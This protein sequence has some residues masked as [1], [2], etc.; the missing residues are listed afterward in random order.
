MAQ[1]A[2]AM[3]VNPIEADGADAHAYGYGLDRNPYAWNM[4]RGPE[5]ERNRIK[6]E[7]W[8]RG[9]A[10]AANATRARLF[11]QCQH[12]DRIGTFL[13]THGRAL[14]SAVFADSV[15]LYRWADANGWRA[16]GGLTSDWVREPAGATL[17]AFAR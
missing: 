3:I 13:R 4:E 11:V 12:G 10:E 1:D 8:A 14:V 6:R 7:A 16:E 17:H 2:Q 9:W 5:I 15:E